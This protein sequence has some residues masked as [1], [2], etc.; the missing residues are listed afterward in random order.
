MNE[1]TSDAAART[2]RILLVDD[3]PTQRLIMARLLKRA[4]YEVESAANG[5]EALARIADGDFQLLITDWEMPEMDGIALCRELRAAQT[6]RYVY[7]ILLTARDSNEHVVAG[8]QAG[9]DDY[10]TKPVIEAELIARLNTGRRIVTLERSLRAANEENR[11][12]SVTDPLTGACNRRYLMEQLPRE[13]ERAARYGRPLAAIMCDIDHFKRINDTHGHLIGD[14][15]LGWFAGRLQAGIRKTDWVAR[16]GGEE[17]VIVLPETPLASAT[18]VAEQ[19][20]SRLVEAPWR[21]G[22]L[23]LAITASFG[24][25]GWNGPVASSATLD[26]LLSQCDAAVYAGKAAGRDRVSV[27]SL[28]ADSG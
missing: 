26:L 19:V 17:F 7:T 13:I 6:R 23:T 15:V 27:R 25:S 20:R 4:G 22:D 1:Q 12:L 18:A 24:V 2:W 10:L 14:D 3:E 11:R 16:Y 5:R 28:E 21:C 9:A 8:L